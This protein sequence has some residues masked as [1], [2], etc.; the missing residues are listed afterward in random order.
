ME[1]EA[2]RDYLV[3]HCQVHPLRFRERRHYPRSFCPSIT[4]RLS[5]LER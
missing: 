3:A 4:G 1:C 2:L 5:R